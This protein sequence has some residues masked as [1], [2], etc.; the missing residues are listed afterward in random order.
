MSSL[1][2]VLWIANIFLDTA[3]RIAFKTAAAHDVR[4]GRRAETHRWSRLLSSPMLWIGIGCFCLE[5]VAWLALLSLIPLSQ[6][7][8]I[9]SINIVTVA[10][11]G[12]ILFHERM[13]PI[14][15]TGI[16]LIAIGVALAGGFG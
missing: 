4:T 7:V 5:F 8:L 9:G 11:A 16:A 6:A 10:V 12:R 3:G 14:R 13:M 2:I 15:L 1:A